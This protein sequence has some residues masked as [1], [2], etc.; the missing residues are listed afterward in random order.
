MSSS[1]KVRK[2]TERLNGNWVS[3]SI[4]KVATNKSAALSLATNPTFIRRGRQRV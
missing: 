3:R 4:K 1:Q 2:K